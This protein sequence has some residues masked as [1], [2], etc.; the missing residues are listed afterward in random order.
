M[1]TPQVLAEGVRAWM[2]SRTPRDSGPPRHI[3]GGQRIAFVM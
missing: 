1:A 2:G 3:G